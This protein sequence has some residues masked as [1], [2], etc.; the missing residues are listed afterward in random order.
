MKFFK[1]S[2]LGLSVLGLLA[3]GVQAFPSM[4]GRGIHK[5][6]AGMLTRLSERLELNDEQV[7]NIG[8]LVEESAALT[9]ERENVLKQLKKSLRDTADRDTF[10]RQAVREIADK[11]A[12]VSTDMMV[13]GLSMRSQIRSLFTPQQRK[14]M[15]EMRGRM[16]ERHKQMGKKHSKDQRGH[17]ERGDSAL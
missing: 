11:I 10:D 14:K 1:I 5:F 13:D 7:S 6:D 2:L 17:G 12:N 8:A 16:K 15:A 4:D 3:T 9:Q